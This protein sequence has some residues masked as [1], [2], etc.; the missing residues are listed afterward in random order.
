MLGISVY[1]QDLDY[2]Y[3]EKA[4]K[5]GA[6]YIFTSLHI[7]EE[8]YSELDKKMPIFL[9]TCRSLDLEIVPDVSPVTFEKL[10]VPPKDYKKLK[11]LG[12]KALRLD[13]GFDDFDTIKE[14]SKNF[15]LML[16]AS[17]VNEEY[18]KEAKEA[19]VDFTN[20]S[21]THNFY[22][23]NNTGLG[24]DYFKEKNRVFKEYDLKVQAFVPGDD[25][26]RFPLYEGLPT[27]ER[28]RQMHPYVSA[29]EL[30]KNCGVDDVLIGDSKAKIETLE[31]I[32][33]Y[34]E[35]KVITIKA[36]FEK[37]YEYL[38][39]EEYTCRKD[40]SESVLRLITPRTSGIR[41]YN[42]GFRRRGSITIDNELMGRYCGEIQL[43]KKDFEA[44]A[45]VNTVGF[46]HPEY[47]DLLEYLDYKTKIR[48]V[49]I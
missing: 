32:N 39:E 28:H 38:Y 29:V 7:P 41:P 6:K 4:A 35:D 11:E 9:E 36:H 24:L 30:I 8:D 16:N 2:D 5:I 12:F 42:N 27:V 45:R 31:Y 10:N 47:V 48:F 33:R 49:R 13:Y 26:K 3:L 21:L 15:K 37:E 43:L 22:P 25:L 17:V 23:R 40:F 20:I 44:D 18:L 34:I 1:F 19:Q 14:L 46:I